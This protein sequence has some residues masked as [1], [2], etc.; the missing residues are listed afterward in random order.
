M[1][2]IPLA[3][4]ERLMRLSGAHRVSK[5]GAEALRDYLESEGRRLTQRAMKFAEHAGRVTVTDGDV[6]LALE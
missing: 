6:K 1:S 2:H 3:S 5:S 4:V